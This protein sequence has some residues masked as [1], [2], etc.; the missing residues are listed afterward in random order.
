MSKKV[1]IDIDNSGLANSRAAAYNVSRIIKIIYK[2]PAQPLQNGQSIALKQ[3]LIKPLTTAQHSSEKSLLLR[4]RLR[5]K[6]HL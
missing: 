6:L 3:I 2:I 1:L 5:I 4:N